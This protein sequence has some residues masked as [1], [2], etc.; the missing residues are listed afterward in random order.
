[1]RFGAS[2]R[3]YELSGTGVC[4][5][6]CELVAQVVVFLVQVASGMMWMMAATMVCQASEPVTSRRC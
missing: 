6:F 2:T 4:D 5:V 1:M 3:D